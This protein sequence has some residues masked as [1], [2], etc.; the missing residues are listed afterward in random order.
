MNKQCFPCRE[1]ANNNRN[2]RQ[3]NIDFN[4]LRPWKEVDTFFKV[5]RS[6]IFEMHFN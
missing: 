3:Q 6:F 2:M 1:I 5:D 4:I